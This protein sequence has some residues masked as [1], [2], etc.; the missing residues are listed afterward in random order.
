[1]RFIFLTQL[2]TGVALALCL[3][4][5]CSKPAK[6]TAELDAS[7][8]LALL[9]DRQKADAHNFVETDLGRFRVTHKQSDSEDPLYVQFHLFGIVPKDREAKLAQLWHKYERRTRDA[10][11]SLVQRSEIDQ[12]CDP[13]L[14]LLKEEVASAINQVLRQRLVIDVAFSDY[15]TDREA[16]MPWSI[17]PGAEAKQPKS[18]GHGGG[19]G[20]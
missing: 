17:P 3:C 1:L 4:T 14:G 10:I 20:H 12:L 16:G 19:H 11:I 5:G 9:Q 7:E 6:T 18:G 8:L 15:S 2:A 13:S